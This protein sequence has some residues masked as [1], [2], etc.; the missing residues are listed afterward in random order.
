M[1]PISLHSIFDTV[2]YMCLYNEVNAVNLLY[3]MSFLLIQVILMHKGVL[4]QLKT[5][6]VH[7]KAYVTDLKVF[8]LL[9]Q[10]S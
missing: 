2:K 10:S 9:E 3:L 4:I 6:F 5:C 1:E 7:S 8:S